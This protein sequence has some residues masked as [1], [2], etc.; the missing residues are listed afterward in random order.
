[1]GIQP[2]RNVYSNHAIIDG[3][4]VKGNVR[5]V[6]CARCA[7]S[8]CTHSRSGMLNVQAKTWVKI[9][10]EYDK[11]IFGH[12]RLVKYLKKIKTKLR[13]NFDL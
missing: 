4:V 2:N 1:M 12:Y 7:R 13:N 9:K 8:E 11:K 3:F 5:I 10:S 6:I